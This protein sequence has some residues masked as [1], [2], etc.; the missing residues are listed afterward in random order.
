MKTQKRKYTKAKPQITALIATRG[1]DPGNVRRTVENLKKC[2]VVV[3]TEE[4]TGADGAWGAGR[5]QHRLAQ[6]AKTKY[7]LKTDAHC[8]FAGKFFDAAIRQ[9]DE[10][11]SGIV[12]GQCEM[13]HG[14][15]DGTGTV[16]CG[17]DLTKDFR[18]V[19]RKAE[20]ADKIVETSGIMGA[21]YVFGRDAYFEFG[22]PLEYLKAWGMEEELL[23]AAFRRHGAK[24]YLLPITTRH[25]YNATRAGRNPTGQ[26]AEW[27]G[28]QKWAAAW[29][30]GADKKEFN[31]ICWFYGNME[32]NEKYKNH[33]AELRA[34]LENC[35]VKFDALF[36]NNPRMAISP[37]LADETEHIDGR[38]G[39]PSISC[40]HEWKT[41][42]Y[43]NGNTRRFCF[44]CGEIKWDYAEGA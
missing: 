17:A 44:W 21:N 25:L 33:G 24:L 8:E 5:I 11:Q 29:W 36:G 34:H 23:T 4:D 26:E 31:N 15:M 43:E 27:V 35:P 38:L 37:M 22:A 30:C 7:L 10:W 39:D 9:L 42:K 41:H 14:D 40:R 32:P 16:Y 6:K 18:C 2:G 3:F 1:E 28:A 12:Y 19:W 20:P 13:V